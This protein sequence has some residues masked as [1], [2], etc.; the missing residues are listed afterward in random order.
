M[1]SAL[2]FHVLLI[3]NSSSSMYFH[4]KLHL[5]AHEKR[6]SPN[7][8]WYPLTDRYK[9]RINI[10]ICYYLLYL[11]KK[12]IFRTRNNEQ[13]C[14]PVE[15]LSSSWQEPQLRY[16]QHEILQLHVAQS[17]PLFTS[18]KLT[19]ETPKQC[20]KSSNLRIS[21]NTKTTSI[22]FFLFLYC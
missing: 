5:S 10:L 8:C 12:L 7:F 19:M 9:T 2:Y 11:S 21:K 22:A 16:S 14:F 3:C 18:L 17:Q 4:I 20:V 1:N 6:E 15:K 13:L